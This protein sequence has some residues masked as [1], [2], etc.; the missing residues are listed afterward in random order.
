MSSTL[1]IFILYN[2]SASLWGKI[3]YGVRR[4]SAVSDG[5][6]ACAALELTHGGL[7]SEEKPEWKAIKNQIP[8]KVEQLF[9]DELPVDV[10]YFLMASLPC[11]FAESPLAA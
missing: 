9:H 7:K 5:P 6:S 10:S 8:A 11:M 2:A 4:L 3:G 1:T